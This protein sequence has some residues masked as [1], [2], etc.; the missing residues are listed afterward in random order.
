MEKNEKLVSQ[1]KEMLTALPDFNRNRIDKTLEPVSPFRGNGPIKLVFIGQ[2]P[3]IRNA[4]RRK[5]ISVTLNLDK[6]G[7]LRT[8]LERIVKGLELSF[9]NVYATNLFKYFYTIPPA[10]TPDVLMAHLQPNID[11]LKEELLDLSDC[12]IITLGEPVLKLLTDDTSK[13]HDYWNYRGCGFQYVKA[14][15]T[16]IGRCVFPFPHQPSINKSLYHE[17]LEAYIEFVKNNM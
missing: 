1:I 8:Y 13:V 14:D 11:I 9:D 5:D 7:A 4:Q 6:S 17:N 16:K 10:D 12:T 15:E 3:T 2:D